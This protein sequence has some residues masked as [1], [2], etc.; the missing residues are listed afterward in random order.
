M[1]G[2]GVGDGA[3]KAVAAADRAAKVG[4]KAGAPEAG[5][6]A[7]APAGGPK[8]K[9]GLLSP[10]PAAG[11]GTGA[12]GVPKENFGLLVSGSLLAKSQSAARLTSC[13]H[14]PSALLASSL[15]KPRATRVATP[16]CLVS[17]ASAFSAAPP[18]ISELASPTSSMLPSV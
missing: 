17:T 3:P 11:A 15:S 1:A 8:A 10:P 2:A 16:S 13:P 6:A 9:A 14:N 7:G 4:P 18:P 5:A 12:G